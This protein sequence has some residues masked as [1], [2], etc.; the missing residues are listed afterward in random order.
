MPSR[1]TFRHRLA[2]VA[3]LALAGPRGAGGQEP[4][5]V[6]PLPAP[7]RGVPTG[8][9]DLLPP[10]PVET[11]Q[12]EPP[13][14]EGAGDPGAVAAGPG[15]A[16][17]PLVAPLPEPE[18][19]YTWRHPAYWFGPAPWD[20]GVE[21]GV[22]G[23]SGTSDSVSM[24]AGG[25]VKR[26]AD[27]YKFNSSLYYNKT[28]SEGVEVQS[29]ALLDVRYDWLFDDSPWTIFVLSQTFYDEFQAFDINLNANTGLGYRW[30]KSERTSL[31]TSLGTGASRE[32]GGPDSEWVPEAQFG[33]DYTLKFGENK[34]FY[35]KADWF[36]EWENFDDYRVLA[37]VGFEFELHQ[38]TNTSLK[39]SA[40][41]RY[42][43][44]PQGVAP[45]NLNYSVM[46]IWKL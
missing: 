44:D 21:I 38:P 3:L 43:S 26:E 13:A 46:L 42:D 15:T 7:K 14:P 23:S 17:P 33:V 39:L 20:S 32:F 36:P 35:A 16:A 9:E 18:P 5:V 40:T 34:K 11:A 22:N 4:A 37:D 24:R 10:A 6:E 2:V 12:A 25:F 31:T 29:N 27:D 28:Q 19:V 45:H 1:G 8:Y 30:L 41:D